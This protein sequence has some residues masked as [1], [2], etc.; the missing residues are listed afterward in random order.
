MSFFFSFKVIKGKQRKKYVVTVSFTLASGR[1]FLWKNDKLVHNHF[2]LQSSVRKKANAG[3]ES[4]LGSWVVGWEYWLD[5]ESLSL[6]WLSDIRAAAT[7]SH[8]LYGF[9]KIL[10]VCCSSIN[11]LCWS[12]L[13]MH[14]NFSQDLETEIHCR[15]IC[16]HFRGFSSDN[17][18]NRP[19]HFLKWAKEIGNF[20]EKK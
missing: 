3:S 20:K 13:G 2:V 15:L 6:V 11:Q 5:I 7:M 19:E 16:L 1:Y 9:R 12:L 14:L 17:A 18:E 8:K 10:D 4:I